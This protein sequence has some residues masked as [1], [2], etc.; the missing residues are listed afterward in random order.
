[1]RLL[2]ERNL[3]QP[4]LKEGWDYMNALSGSSLKINSTVATVAVR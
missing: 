4:I 3:G 2:A 1:M